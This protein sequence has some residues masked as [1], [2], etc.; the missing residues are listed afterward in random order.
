[1]AWFSS[2][3]GHTHSY[4]KSAENQSYFV[5]LTR[6]TPVTLDSHA[7][8]ACYTFILNV[9]AFSALHPATRGKLVQTLDSGSTPSYK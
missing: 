2:E 9:V 4:K 5:L 6:L 7:F 8:L 1:M 3:G